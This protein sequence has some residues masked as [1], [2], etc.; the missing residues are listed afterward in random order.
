MSGSHSA[1]I[2]MLKMK[3]MHSSQNISKVQQRNIVVM[4]R[5]NATLTLHK[6]QKQNNEHV[7]SDDATGTLKNYF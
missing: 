7:F 3:C 6:R 1:L 2:P 5:R 4:F